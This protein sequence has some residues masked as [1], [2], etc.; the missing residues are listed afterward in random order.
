VLELLRRL[1]AKL[2]FDELA[3]SVLPINHL[4]LSLVQTFLLSLTNHKVHVLRLGFFLCLLLLASLFVDRLLLLGSICSAPAV[5]LGLGLSHIDPTHL[6]FL[7]VAVLSCF[8]GLFHPLSL[9]ATL[10]VVK[11]LGVTHTLVN[12]LACTL[13][14]FVDFLDGLALLCLEETD[15]VD[16]K[17]QILLG[18][19]AGLFGEDPFAVEDF[20]IIILIWSQVD[21]GV[22]LVLAVSDLLVHLLLR[23]GSQ[24][25]LPRS[26]FIGV[27][28]FRHSN[29]AVVNIMIKS[30]VS[31][32]SVN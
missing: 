27:F 2:I 15:P 9:K 7:A 14:R 12:D 8:H 26:L 10:L 19:L 22:L 5:I 25:L 28:L 16:E 20:V 13:T 32:I 23:S 29:L 24:F 17:A 21:L 31:E 18:L 30:S 11:S 6:V 3:C 1:V 4:H